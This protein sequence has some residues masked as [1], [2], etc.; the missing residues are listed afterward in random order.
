MQ[1]AKAR[2]EIDAAEVTKSTLE[3]QAAHATE[4]LH[5]WRTSVE[6]DGAILRRALF[7]EETYL[8]DAAEAEEA[9]EG[10]ARESRGTLTKELGQLT[11]NE[12]ALIREQARL[13]AAEQ[14]FESVKAQLSSDQL[15]EANEETS[16][17]ILRWAAT[18]NAERTAEA[19]RLQ[20]ATA[21]RL[22]EQADH[23][24]AK[25]EGEEAAR[26]ETSALQQ[27]K[28]V[29]EGQA[30]QE[31]LSQLPALRQA[32]DAETANPDSPALL[33]AL[34]RL[35]QASEREVSLSDVRLAELHAAKLS[36]EKTELAGDSLDVNAVVAR[37]RELGVKSAKPYNAYISK[38]LPDADQAR[39]L[40]ASN[41]ARFMGV[42]VA[43]TE[44]Q[45]AR[46]IEAHAP[47]LTSPVVVSISALDAE[48]SREDSVTLSASDDARFNIDAAATLL[49]TLETQLSAESD[50]RRLFA[51]RHREAQVGK[52][53]LEAYLARFGAAAIQQAVSDVTRLAAEA[54]AAK[55]RAAAATNTANEHRDT[56]NQRQTEA[57]ACAAAATTAERYARDLERFAKTHEE[58]HAVRTER[59]LVIS[60]DIAAIT[61]RRAEISLEQEKQESLEK[62]AFLA[63]ER[64]KLQANQL[65]E[66]RGT[67]KYYDKAFDAAASL[68]EN[69]Q[70]LTVLRG[71]Y[72]N[73]VQTFETRATDRLGLLQQQLNQARELCLEKTKA[74]TKNFPGIGYPDMAPYLKGN[75]DA[76]IPATNDEIDAADKA[77]RE[78]DS[79]L[80][81]E[82]NQ[83]K[84][85]HKV[86]KPSYEP[87]PEMLGWDERE[88]SAAIDLASTVKQASADAAK[89]AKIAAA[90]AKEL[91]KQADAEAKEAQNVAKMLRSALA[92]SELLVADPIE[93][94]GDVNLQTTAVVTEFQSR[95]KKVE[96]TRS[97]AHKAFDEMKTSAMRKELQEVEPDIAGQLQKNEFDA[98]CA[99]SQRLL[100]GIVD[101]IGTT[102]SGLDGMKE[103]F[104]ACVGELSNLANSAL[105]LLNSAVNN[106]KVPVGAPYVGGKSVI[107]M[108][109]RF[110]EIPHE[111]RR[112][113]LHNYLD[114]LIDSN[115]VPARGPEL[116]AEALLRIHGKPLG[117]QM[118]KM[119]P[120]E[121]LQ[122][123]A[124]DKIQNSGGEGVVMAMFLYLLINQL[125]SETQAKLKKTG[126]G[127]LILDNPFAKATTP[128]LWKAQRLL[129]QSMDVQLI[130]ATALPDYNT[131]GEFSRFNRLRKAG[132]NT[133][134]GRWHLEVAD[135]KLREQEPETV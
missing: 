49:A 33:I 57:Q 87:T 130:F 125:R 113:A 8:R 82:K 124:V 122:Y 68:A 45:K 29:A 32:A 17:A 114:S 6:K 81:V 52:Q 4:E 39:R 16:A 54:A 94:L 37:L 108:R 99:D 76:L 85:F 20:E 103:D 89:A 126:G 19:Q 24:K 128:T 83:S 98:A 106:K 25:A 53:Q 93:L 50:R 51:S 38:A 70:Q 47:K 11:T 34:D 65:G 116:V 78:A 22:K 66:E 31:R 5:P 58:G 101:R 26:L 21:L 105:A 92:L 79:A 127:P 134:T 10:A 80:A 1:A 96:G 44:F 74:F 133:K 73:A 117:L 104:E 102:Q 63:K 119:V 35:A 86:S 100:E 121:A 36:I 64:L 3:A 132:K 7:T 129:A 43:A 72:A 131:V 18:T 111:A 91:A 30:E 67:L 120:D 23:A 55:E 84:E 46:Q 27:Q 112:Q 48:L 123:V 77:S 56:A 71:L 88:L 59:L 13:V 15:L 9:K 95:S 60:T 118:L 12:T 62:G 75:F 61:E 109:A 42:C 28:F 110:H 135:F 69:P 97:K 107:K 90:R 14:A 40:I 115:I 41:P 2:G